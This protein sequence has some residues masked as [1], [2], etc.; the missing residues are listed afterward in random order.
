[1]TTD[2]PAYH[3]VIPGSSKTTNSEPSYANKSAVIQRNQDTSDH[4]ENCCNGVIM[5]ANEAY[6]VHEPQ[7]GKSCEAIMKLLMHKAIKF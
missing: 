1:M 4:L 5:A 7:R 6:V 2:N 3:S